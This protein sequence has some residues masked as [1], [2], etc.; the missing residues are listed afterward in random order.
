MKVIDI[1]LL[2]IVHAQYDLPQR[3]RAVSGLDNELNS[4]SVCC[5]ALWLV[6]LA[7]VKCSVANLRDLA[8]RTLLTSVFT[9]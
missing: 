3:L 7:T 4:L 8:F 9:H 5:H 6:L 2:V 1:S